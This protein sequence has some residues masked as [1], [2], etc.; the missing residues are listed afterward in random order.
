VTQIS[1]DAGERQ[2]KRARRGM[3]LN[4]GGWMGDDPA[5]NAVHILE[6]P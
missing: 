3:A 4:A 6:A 2:V 5:I 1:G